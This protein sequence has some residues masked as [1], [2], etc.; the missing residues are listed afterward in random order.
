M[1]FLQ[2][3]RQVENTE[4]TQWS[5]SHSLLPVFFVLQPRNKRKSTYNSHFVHN[6]PY[7]TALQYEKMEWGSMYKF[8]VIFNTCNSFSLIHW[9]QIAENLAD[10]SD[11]FFVPSISKSCWALRGTLYR[12][13]FNLPCGYL[14]HDQKE[15]TLDN[16]LTYFA[17]HRTNW[18]LFV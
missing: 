4:A 16:V 6:I 12:V 17:L 5:H 14:V 18:K 3:H 15:R 2:L 8:F 13:L 11:W 7:G 1:S 9:S 10:S